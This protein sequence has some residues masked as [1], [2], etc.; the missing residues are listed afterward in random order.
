MP[1]GLGS[2]SETLPPAWG[3]ALR[4]GRGVPGSASVQGTGPP[5]ACQECGLAAA[6]L[7]F[8]V[9]L[10]APSAAGR[11]RRGPEV[12]TGRRKPSLSLVPDAGTL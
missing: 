10:W 8:L 7:A 11:Y 3:L 9:E 2:S 5:L 6:G 4:A 1:K 12:L